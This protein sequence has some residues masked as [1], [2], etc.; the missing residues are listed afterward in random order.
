MHCQ[1]YNMITSNFRNSTLAALYRLEWSAESKDKQSIWEGIAVIQMQDADGIE[2]K[3]PVLR[4]RSEH[5]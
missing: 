1:L 5:I 2:W 3:I 4:E